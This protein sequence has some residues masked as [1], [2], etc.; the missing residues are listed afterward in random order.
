LQ[1]QVQVQAVEAQLVLDLVLVVALVVAQAL[2]LVPQS[3][4]QLAPAR[5][6]G[7]QSVR[8]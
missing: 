7:L 3:V 1:A 4:L 5:V 6:S 8:Q 2:V